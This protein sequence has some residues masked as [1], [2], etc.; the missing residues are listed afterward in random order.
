[1]EEQMD[2]I[3]EAEAPETAIDPIFAAIAEHKALIKETPRFEAAAR[4]ARSRAEISMGNASH[5]R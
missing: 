4:A 3:I 2:K 1:M 5:P